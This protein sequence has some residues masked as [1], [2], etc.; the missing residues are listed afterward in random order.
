MD[1][2]VEQERL[3]DQRDQNI[4]NKRKK[5]DEE[6]DERKKALVRNQ[7]IQANSGK[8]KGTL[9]RKPCNTVH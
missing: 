2:K 4:L 3:S 9:P 8:F 6:E 1:H 5:V 7:E